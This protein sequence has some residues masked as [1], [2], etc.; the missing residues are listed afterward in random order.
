MASAIQSIR[1]AA[2]DNNY[3]FCQQNDT[4]PYVVISADSGIEIAKQ[5]NLITSRNLSDGAIEDVVNVIFH[6]IR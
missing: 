5:Y 1:K 3:S 2:G 4:L 6:V